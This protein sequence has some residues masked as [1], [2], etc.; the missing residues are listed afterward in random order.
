MMKET[1]ILI[2]GTFANSVRN[3]SE[4]CMADNKEEFQWYLPGSSFCK[5]LDKY[6]AERNCQIRTWAHLRKG[7]KPFVWG[8]ENTWLCRSKSARQLRNY[9]GRL[10][11]EGWKCHIIAHSHG[12]NILLEAFHSRIL[13]YLLFENSEDWELG[14]FVILGTPILK[15]TFLNEPFV[16]QERLMPLNFHFTELFILL[17]NFIFFLL[18][19]FPKTFLGDGWNVPFWFG[20]SSIVFLFII[21]LIILL[22]ALLWTIQV[23]AEGGGFNMAYNEAFAEASVLPENGLITNK[24]KLLVINSNNDEAYLLLSII[25]DLKNPWGLR[26]VNVIKAIKSAIK[27]ANNYLQSIGIKI[28]EVGSGGWSGLK[29]NSG[30]LLLG[31][32]VWISVILLLIVNNIDSV[33]VRLIL[34]LFSLGSAYSLMFFKEASRKI[35]TLPIYLIKIIFKYVTSFS[36]KLIEPVILNLAFRISRRKILGFENPPF[37]EMEVTVFKRAE[38]YPKSFSIFTNAEDLIDENIL[39][40]TNESLENLNRILI[41]NPI[42]ND[43]RII[44]ELSK[45]LKLNHSIYFDEEFDLTKIVEFITCS[46]EEL[47]IKYGDGDLF[48]EQNPIWD[49]I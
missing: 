20:V 22:F 41:E 44:S 27:S 39:N 43:E 9:I 33:I 7:E 8:G 30:E 34:I 2:H 1:V 14:K 36:Y 13:D 24:T 17:V 3:K 45:T 49:K 10:K 25:K 37:N 42:A 6:F 40:L 4:D 35:I 32:L 18:L 12:G 11:K 31:G 16:N 46:D 38:V 48:I 29:S 23:G 5:K 15:G 19:L 47:K 26:K 28:D 21:S